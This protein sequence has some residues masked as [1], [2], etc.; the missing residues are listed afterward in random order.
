MFRMVE[1]WNV[2]EHCVCIVSDADLQYHL[3][4][5]LEPIWVLVLAP[6]T[7]GTL[8]YVLSLAVNAIESAVKAVL[9]ER[10]LGRGYVRLVVVVVVVGMVCCATNVM[11]CAD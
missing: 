2:T 3:T 6:L 10:R 4:N 1:G 7:A 9:A 11:N 5:F 8:L